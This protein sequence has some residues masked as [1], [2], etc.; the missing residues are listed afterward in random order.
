MKLFI[1][2]L[3]ALLCVSGA[4]AEAALVE[5]VYSSSGGME[6]AST[7]LTLRREAQASDARLI[8]E[9]RTWDET[10]IADRAVSRQALEDLDEFVQRY[11]PE[12]WAELPDSEFI[13]LDAPTRLITLTYDNGTLYS[14]SNSKE[15]SGALFWELR[16]FL[17]SYLADDAEVFSLFLPSSGGSGS[18]W[19]AVLSDPAFVRVEKQIRSTD[20]GEP[21]L[22]GNDCKETFV[23]YGRIPGTVELHIEATGG[24]SVPSESAVG[25][26][27][28]L[29]VDHNYNVK[30]IEKKKHVLEE[31]N[32]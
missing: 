28:V 10:M 2:L 26:I 21:L 13:A 24:L 1:L 20:T 9:E 6:N 27:Y 12:T 32:P 18:S 17:E 4:S 3:A 23:F 5:C 30:L 15:L 25:T 31:D 14:L 19:Q 29:E 8:S 22:P 11:A 7:C 16:C